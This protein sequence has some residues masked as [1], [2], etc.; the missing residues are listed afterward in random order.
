MLKSLILAGVLVSAPAVAGGLE[1]ACGGSFMA[2]CQGTEPYG[3]SGHACMSRHR[4]Q[5]PK[6]CLIAIRDSG[7]ASKL[8]IA[9]F[10]H[11]GHKTRVARK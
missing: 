5:L 9:E 2:Y 11:G 1:E 3:A 7:M 4:H 10:K 6:A 8:E